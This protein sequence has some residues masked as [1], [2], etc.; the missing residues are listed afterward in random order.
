MMPSAVASPCQ[1]SFHFTPPSITPGMAVMVTSFK[2]AGWGNCLG[3]AWAASGAAARAHRSNGLIEGMLIV[4]SRSEGI[5]R[6]AGVGLRVIAGVGLRVIAGV[7]L[8]P[9]A[10][11]R[12]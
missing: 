6:T 12:E 1:I 2:G 7:G 4:I 9:R 5:C 10:R 11:W 3:W 8:R